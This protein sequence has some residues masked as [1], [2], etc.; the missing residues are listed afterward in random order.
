MKRRALPGIFAVL[1][2]GFLWGT[3]GTAATFAPTVGPLAMGAAALGVG[4]IL[5][6]VIAV[7]ALHNKRLELKANLGT[8]IAGAIGVVIYPLAF[9]S[10]M[11]LA[12]VAV[13]T[14]ISLGSAP[15]ISG[16]L[17]RVIE[18]R[19]LSIWWMLSA[20]L[21]IV[22][23]ATLCA[24]KMHGAPNDVFPTVAG[25][26]LGLFAG[27]TYA[28]YSWSAQRLMSRN[29]GRAAAMGAVF[30]LGGVA[31]MPVLLLT[32]GPFITSSQAF[33]V[34]SYMA[35]VPMFLGYL[36]FGFGLT[37]VASSSATT[38]TLVEPAVAAALAVIIVGEQL[39]LVAWAGMVG[40]GVSLT[41]L[42]LA[43]ATQAGD[44]TRPVSTRPTREAKNH[45][46]RDIVQIRP[47]PAGGDS[48]LYK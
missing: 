30:G 41:I 42:A 44:S 29:I 20:A 26:A 9:Y 6:A 13:G 14:V 19:T 28:L 27:A 15:I 4:G 37:R 38:L 47:E 8:V 40:I 45:L 35:L 5:Q 16:V 3:T 25:I 34:G 10:S 23:S 17:E 39:S 2:A 32:G 24:A 31:L 48:E 22:G 21:G 1:I 43:P 33:A 11:H 18:K 36:L 12:G 7:P 46:A